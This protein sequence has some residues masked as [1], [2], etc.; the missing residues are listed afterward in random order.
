LR[1]LTGKETT[2]AIRLALLRALGEIRAIS[3]PDKAGAGAAVACIP[4]LEEG[5]GPQEVMLHVGGLPQ[6]GVT[7]VSPAG[8]R[9]TDSGPTITLGLGH[10]AWIRCTASVTADRTI[11]VDCSAS[12]QSPARTT[13]SRPC[14]DHI[15][16]LAVEIL[17]RTVGRGDVTGAV[18]GIGRQLPGVL[19]C[20]QVDHAIACPEAVEGP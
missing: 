16:D 4:L 20:Q 5:D 13:A 14:G 2:W 12:A 18:N 7:A 10:L 15:S 17:R 3:A 1:P 8:A 9:P 11:V 6:G 19:L